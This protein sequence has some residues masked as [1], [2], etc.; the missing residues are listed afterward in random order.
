MVYSYV[1]YRNQNELPIFDTGVPDFNM[2]ELYRTNRYVGND[3]IGDANQ[4]AL[5]MTTRLINQNTGVQYLPGN[6]R[7]DPLL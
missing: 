6:R 7:S 5:G 1:P 3:R 4:V 2:A